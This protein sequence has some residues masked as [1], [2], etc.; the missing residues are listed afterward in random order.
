VH[1]NINTPKIKIE[2]CILSI[3]QPLVG[4]TDFLLALKMSDTKNTTVESKTVNELPTE[5]KSPSRSSLADS[6]FKAILK[7]YKY[8]LPKPV[9]KGVVCAA[10]VAGAVYGFKTFTNTSRSP[11]E[12]FIDGIL[13]FGVG[14][15]LAGSTTDFIL[16]FIPN[17]LY[18]LVVLLSIGFAGVYKYNRNKS[19]FTRTDHS[20]D[21]R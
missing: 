8:E 6:F 1:I 17:I 5:T 13:G 19:G 15:F 16:T 2:F 10:T 3:N 4:L 12:A 20:T 21:D 11:N 9:A 7:L 18:W 14:G